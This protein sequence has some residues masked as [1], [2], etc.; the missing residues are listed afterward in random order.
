RE[1]DPDDAG[2]WHG[3]S[4]WDNQALFDLNGHPLP[5]LN[6]FKYIDTGAVADLKIDSIEDI[7]VEADA[8]ENIILPT[9]VIAI[10]N[11]GSKSPVP[12]TWDEEAI[13]QAK[14]NG[15]GSYDIEGVTDSGEHVV[16]HLEI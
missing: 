11:D 3:G 4:S 16:A 14:S 8:G 2:Q 5:S 7:S 1:Y 6:V 9:T 15:V 13:Q 12:V 10:Y